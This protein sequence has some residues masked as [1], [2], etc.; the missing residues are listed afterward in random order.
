M[1]V[2]DVLLDKLAAVLDELREVDPVVL[3]TADNVVALHR[4]LERLAAITTRATAAFDTSKGWEPDGAR[5]CAAWLAA[6]CRLPMTA[7]QRRVR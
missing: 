2:G 4:Q 5:V 1:S 6:R 7:A 3:G